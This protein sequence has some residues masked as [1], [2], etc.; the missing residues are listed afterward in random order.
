MNAFN[1]DEEERKARRR[2]RLLEMH[3]KSMNSPGHKTAERLLKTTPL[4]D[5][6]EAAIAEH[7]G[8]C[9]KLAAENKINA[10]N[11]FNLHLI[12]Y[13]DDLLHNDKLENFQVS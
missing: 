4:S 3:Q 6:S 12:D 13:M 5:M 1:D 2:S 8:N 7:Y 9:I 10:K 11:A